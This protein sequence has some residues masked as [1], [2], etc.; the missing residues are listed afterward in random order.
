MKGQTP[1]DV[2]SESG[3]FVFSQLIDVPKNEHTVA[4]DLWA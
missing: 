4:L 1:I 2:F 3:Q